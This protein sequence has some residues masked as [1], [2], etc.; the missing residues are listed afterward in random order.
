[1]YLLLVVDRELNLEGLST[2]V[3]LNLPKQDKHVALRPFI[4]LIS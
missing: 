1:M 4:H 2:Q 3:I